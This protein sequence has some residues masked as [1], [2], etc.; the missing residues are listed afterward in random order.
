M[1]LF[2]FG[3]GVR[4]RWGDGGGEGRRRCKE[5]KVGR[6]KRRMRGRSV[7]ETRGGEIKKGGKKEKGRG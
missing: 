5:R 2:V 7:K 3:R 4:E 1:Y 6:K